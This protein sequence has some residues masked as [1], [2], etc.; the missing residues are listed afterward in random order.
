MEL[1]LPA[2][3]L[4]SLS[5]SCFSQYTPDIAREYI[6]HPAG[7]RICYDNSGHLLSDEEE[8]DT[9]TAMKNS[10]RRTILDLRV[11]SRVRMV[12][13]PY[14]GDRGFVTGQLPEGHYKMEF[15]HTLDYRKCETV[16]PY[17]MAHILGCWYV[18]AAVKG[19]LAAIPIVNC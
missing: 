15:T 9:D 12:S 11:G 18:E 1:L 2:L 19:T 7:Y 4:P 17:R 14:E 5:P 8:G 10:S 6:V 3:G 13:G 16:A